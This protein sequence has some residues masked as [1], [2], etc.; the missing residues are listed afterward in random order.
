MKHLFVT[1]LA[2]AAALTTT[3]CTNAQTT[4]T[5]VAPHDTTTVVDSTVTH[6][7]TT[8][9]E[10]IEVPSKKMGRSI[11]NTVTLPEKYLTEGDSTRYPVLYLLH[12]YGDTNESWPSKYD[13]KTAANQ[14]GVIIVCPDGQNSWYFDSPIDPKMQFETFVSQE[15]VEYI[16]HNYRTRD[17][18]N[19]RAITGLSMGG[20]GALYLAFRHPEVYGSCGS[21]SGGVDI[22]KFPDRWT[23][24]KRLG[25]YS[26]NQ[27]VWA[28]NAVINQLD[29]IKPGQ[30]NIIIDDGRQDF[31]YEV[32]MNL[33][34]ALDKR[35]IKHSFTI[36]PGNHSWKYWCFS[37]PQHLN[38]FSQAFAGQ[39]VECKTAIDNSHAPK[40]TA[41]SKKVAPAKK[42]TTKTKK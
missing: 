35:G 24:E 37:L 30:L 25:K 19:G 39:Q 38:F 20:H 23:I 7:Q 6:A 36:R 4:Q 5:T 18:R 29:K 3:S 14:Y 27:K 22:T 10:V 8:Q 17:N 42:D 15:L 2:L 33:H 26:Q 11:N 31:F 41:N 21:M 9:Q 16:D 32:N 28:Q 12:G 40:D 1:I 13:L 34:N